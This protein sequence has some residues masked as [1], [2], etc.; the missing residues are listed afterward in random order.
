MRAFLAP[1]S[2]MA[3]MQNG[4]DLNKDNLMKLLWA[5]KPFLETMPPSNFALPPISQISNLDAMWVHSFWET[6]QVSNINSAFAWTFVCV[7]SLS[8]MKMFGEVFNGLSENQRN[9]IIGWLKERIA[10]SEFKCLSKPPLLSLLPPKSQSFKP[11]VC[12]SKTSN[13]SEQLNKAWTICSFL[14]ILTAYVVCKIKITF[15]KVEMSG[16]SRPSTCW[17]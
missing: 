3:I 1:L 14:C 8:S 15:N 5:A 16:L 17:Q 12:K 11:P 4:T 7:F 6:Q 10:E 9:E 2:W 13:T